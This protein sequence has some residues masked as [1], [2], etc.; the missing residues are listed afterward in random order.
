MWPINYN[1]ILSHTFPTRKV[2]QK[3]S[4]ENIPLKMED[5]DFSKTYSGIKAFNNLPTYVKNL[6]QTKKQIK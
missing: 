3:K 1:T 6:L 5:T 2:K 4:S